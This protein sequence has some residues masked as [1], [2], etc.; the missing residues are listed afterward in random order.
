MIS[1]DLHGRLSIGV[2]SR[3]ESYVDNSY[4]VEERFNE[5]F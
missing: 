3:L 1:E 4:F 5:V 2:V